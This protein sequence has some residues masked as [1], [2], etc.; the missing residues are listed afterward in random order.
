MTDERK[1]KNISLHPIGFRLEEV[2]L[3]LVSLPRQRFLSYTLG[4]WS[5]G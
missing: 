2:R 3:V 5:P 1:G 4:F